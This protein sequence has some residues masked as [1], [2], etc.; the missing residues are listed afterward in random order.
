MGPGLS[1]SGSNGVGEAFQPDVRLESL[2]YYP[3][4]PNALSPD[5]GCTVHIVL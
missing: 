3:F 4:F 1:P 5:R 2:T